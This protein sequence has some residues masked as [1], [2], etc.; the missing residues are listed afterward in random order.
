M[1]VFH[2]SGIVSAFLS[3][4]AFPPR[5]GVKEEGV[6]IENP[7][8]EGLFTESPFVEGCVMCVGKGLVEDG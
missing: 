6:L 2:I 3:G 1:C 7:F 8:V 5:G 4:T